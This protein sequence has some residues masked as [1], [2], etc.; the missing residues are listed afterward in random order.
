MQLPNI[1]KSRRFWTGIVG[2]V[3]MVLVQ[4]VPGI[5]EHADILTNAIL[6]LIGLLIGGYSLEDAVLAYTK[7]EATAQKLNRQ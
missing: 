5:M 4:I 7:P 2:V 1:L 3:M 6:I